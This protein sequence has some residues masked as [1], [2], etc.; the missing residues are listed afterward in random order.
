MEKTL[1]A[2]TMLAF[3][4]LT[5]VYSVSLEAKGPD[6]TSD[7]DS[8]NYMRTKSYYKEFFKIN[9][10]KHALAPWWEL[11]NKYPESS[12]RLYVDG[13]K[14]YRSYIESAT[15][16]PVKEKYIDT[17]M[18]IY[19]QR[20]EYFGGEGN[21][22]GRKGKDLFTYGRGDIENVE[23]AYGMLKKSIEIEGR[24]SREPVILSFIAADIM[25][26]KRDRIEDRQV[27]EDY[28]TVTAI[29]E[30]LEGKSSR[31]KKTRATIHEIML[32]EELL[33]CGSLNSYFVPQF[34]SLKHDQAFLL[35]VI[36]LYTASGCENA[37]IYI[38]ASEEMYKLNP[39]PVEAHDLAM[40]FVAKGD[41]SKAL[42]YLQFAVTGDDI[43]NE[44]RADWFYKLA[45]I[46]SASEDF[47]DAISYAREAILNKSDCG[48][49]YVVL[50]DLIVAASS[51]MTDEFDQGAAYW[52]AADQYAKA[53]SLDPSV[54]S[55]AKQKLAANQDQYP[56]K[57]EVFFRDMEEGASY[58]IAGCINEKTTVRA[59]K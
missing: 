8:I 13:A 21:V 3:L 5:T 16:G 20:M 4:F 7:E 18:L 2:L 55:E 43:N 51:R 34:E 57:E 41:Y 47:C 17:L 12:E 38:S 39:G 6:F 9:L 36:K 49:A 54:A 23:N 46:S 52:A 19:D 11:F 33:S 48:K 44:T 14:M 50:G 27:V 22:L 45:I 26:S 56:D 59:R 30:Q 29:L 1:K 24:K 35:K 31:W 28:L 40:M 32:K 42:K 15:E 25:L 37:E 10:Y 58:Q 53:A